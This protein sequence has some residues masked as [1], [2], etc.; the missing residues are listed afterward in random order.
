[1]QI[2]DFFEVSR[3]EWEPCTVLTG[4]LVY[5]NTWYELLHLQIQMPP[6]LNSKSIKPWY[7]IERLMKQNLFSCKNKA[8]TA[9]FLECCQA[10]LPTLVLEIGYY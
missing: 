1:M 5:F 3:L 6:R 9:H 8:D 2:Q 7:S 10:M 4:L